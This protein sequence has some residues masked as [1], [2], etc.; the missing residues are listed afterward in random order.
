VWIPNKYDSD[1]AHVAIYNG[2]KAEAVEVDVPWPARLLDPKDVYGK[3]LVAGEGKLRV[4]MAG[5]F[6]AF[7]AFKE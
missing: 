5:E 7:V 4:P 6:A 2:A 3:P 1:R